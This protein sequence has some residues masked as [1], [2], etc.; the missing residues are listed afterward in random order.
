MMNEKAQE[1]GC[2]DT[3]F[4]N[5]NGLHDENHYTTAHDLAMIAQEAY[6]NEEFRKIVGSR[7]YT[8]PATNKT[9]EERVLANHHALLGEGDWHY[10][11]CLGGKTGYTDTALNTLVTYFEKDGTVYICVVLHYK[12]TEVFTDTVMLAEYT[13]EFEKLQVSQK[14]YTLSGGTAVVPKGTTTDALEIQSTQ[15]ED[16]NEQETF[17][18]NGYEVGQAVVDKKAYEADKKAEEAQKE[19]ESKEEQSQ[20]NEAQSGSFSTFEMAV[21][22]LVGLIG[23]GLILIVISVIKKKKKK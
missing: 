2:K 17:L 14:K 4:V 18:F 22:V 3:H 9:A 12:G 1:I 8:I 11:G 13:K 16:G 10:D 19:E 20:N 15:N 23:L 6:K 5:A 7:Y 21:V